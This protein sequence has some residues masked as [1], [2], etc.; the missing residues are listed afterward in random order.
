MPAEYWTALIPAVLALLG[1][2]TA[3]VRVETHNH[4]QDRAAKHAARVPGSQDQSCSRR[5]L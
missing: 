1:A 3:L 4:A 2:L 5:T